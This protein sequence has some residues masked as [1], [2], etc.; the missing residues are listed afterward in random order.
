[1]RVN[2]YKTPT[3]GN[4]EQI[5]YGVEWHS[6]QAL[7]RLLVLSV[8]CIT[9]AACATAPVSENP[10]AD[11]EAPVN[12]FISFYFHEYKRGLPGDSQL[13]ELGNFVTPELLALFE[14]ANQGEDCYAKQFNHEGA[15]AVQGDLFSSLFEGA[16]SAT[17]RLIALGSDT[18]IAEIE[19]TNDDKHLSPEAFVWRDRVFLV[20]TMNGWRIADFT[21]DGTWEF[22]MDGNV[23]QILRTVAD[24]C[25]A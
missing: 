2:G 21:H 18:A 16:T 10:A 8:A 1:M 19:W 15:P 24:E 17:Y 22:M 6:I 3:D 25:A 13:A 14:A 20:N 23:S 7:S 9:A 11:V 12:R 5:P 4:S